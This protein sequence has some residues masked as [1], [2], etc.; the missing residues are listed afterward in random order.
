MTG[1]PTGGPSGGRLVGV[2]AARG[3][4]L[5][6]MM[7]V[8]ITPSLTPQGEVST[9]YLIASGR[10]SA[11]FAVL[12]G[13]GLAL[14]S[15]G[16]EPP[17]G[18]SLGGVWAGTAARAGVLLLV[19]L[20]LGALD[21][22]V[23]VILAYYAVLFVFALPFMTLPST[24]LLPLAAAWAIV[25]PVINHAIRSVLPYS[26][27]GVPTLESLA[28]P[29]GLVQ[30][31]VFSGYYPAFPWTAYLLL[32]LGI[33]RLRGLRT[34]RAAVVMVVAGAGVAVAARVSSWLLLE[35]GGLDA[36]R[37]AGAGQTPVA[38]RP[39]DVALQTSFYGTSPT[40]T[41][42][43]LAVDAPHSATPFDLLHTMGS[44]AAVLGLM[45][46]VA[47]RFR[48]LVWPL[49][50]P[51]SMTLTLYS[52]HV[53]LLATVLPDTTPHAL[54]IHVAIAFAV[55]IPWRLF[56]RRGPLE[57]FTASVS[58]SARALVTGE[59]PVSGPGGRSADR[60]GS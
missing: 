20:T 6:G 32:G 17:R 7:A 23:A 2:D 45:L 54:L 49:A 39:L 28:D 50:A 43:W 46:L 24:V 57:A 13:V 21:S 51:G 29:A 19:G 15:G 52:L 59:L 53:V 3:W 47:Y 58:L 30:E 10:A 40:T 18:R 60:R 1:A 38:G 14:A 41:W 35:S 8:H 11:L 42:W 22:G 33:G 16:S 5:F 12:A 27:P 25:T 9:E 44:A 48:A 56:F 37:D 34:L 36:L 31:L 26:W 55:A 4:A